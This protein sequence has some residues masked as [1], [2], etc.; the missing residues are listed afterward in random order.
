MDNLLAPRPLKMSGPEHP[1]NEICLVF[2]IHWIEL[3]NREEGGV[4]EEILGTAE[5]LIFTQE[6]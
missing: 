2:L 6:W 1:P 3:S 4:G 5:K